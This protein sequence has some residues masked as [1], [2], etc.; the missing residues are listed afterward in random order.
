MRGTSLELRFRL[1]GSQL[2]QQS[3]EAERLRYNLKI[4]TSL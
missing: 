1:L 2:L 3:Q 4:K